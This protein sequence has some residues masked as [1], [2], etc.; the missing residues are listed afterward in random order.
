MNQG[1]ELCMN[2]QIRNFFRTAI[3]YFLGHWADRQSSAFSELTFAS[4]GSGLSAASPPP[5]SSDLL[6]N[7]SELR[8]A[9]AASSSSPLAVTLLLPS[10]MLE[11][12]FLSS[13][14][15]LTFD[16]PL[17]GKDQIS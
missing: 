16:H 8:C 10:P 3:D 4:I 17:E 9:N 1:T 6:L 14:K 5:I 12:E 15:R 7:W 13:E 11:L 2:L